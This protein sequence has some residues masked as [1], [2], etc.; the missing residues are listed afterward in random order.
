[1]WRAASIAMGVLVLVLLVPLNLQVRRRPEEI[2]TGP[3]GDP[4]ERTA[5]A[6]FEDGLDAE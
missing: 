4:P 6:G 5:P 2:G 1:M 3:D